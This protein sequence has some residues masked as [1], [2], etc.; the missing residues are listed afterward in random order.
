MSS[1]YL[2]IPFC[3]RKCI[4]C[5]FYSIENLKPM[6]TFVEALQKEISMY[7][8]YSHREKVETIFFGGGT[9]SLLS[10][11]SL[12][13]IFETLHQNYEINPDAEITLE[14]N[15]GTVDET[16]LRSFINVGIN[17]LSFGVQSFHQN[18]L[19]FLGRIHNSEQAMNSVKSA[20]DVG[21]ENINIDL[22]YSLPQQ[23]MK[24]WEETLEK[25]LALKTQHISA[26]SLIVEPNTPLHRMVELKQI[27]PSP[28]EQEAEMY[29]FTMKYLQERGFIH[30]E[31]SN[32]AR[33]GFESKHN[34]NYWNHTNYLGFGPSAHSFWANRR[35]WNVKNLQLYIE[36]IANETFPTESEETLSNTQLLD[37]AIMLGLRSNS[38]DLRT[39]EQRFGVNLRQVHQAKIQELV[40]SKLAVFKGNKLHLTDNGFLL[41]DSIAESLLIQLQAA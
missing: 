38:L 10:D 39:I 31:V 5:D 22:I 23:S 12:K 40:A 14:A 1:I 36:R 34:S 2:H 6:L 25:A 9:P 41:C 35:W 26:Y 7:K 15:P 29:E 4:Y 8:S 21:F 19:E 18:E 28:T 3:E 33:P 17:R 27:T 37:E 20:Q 24:N 11:D 13:R 32:Y 30:Y 16:K